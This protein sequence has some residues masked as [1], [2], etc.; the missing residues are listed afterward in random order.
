MDNFS[1]ICPT[2]RFSASLIFSRDAA[3]VY[4]SPICYLLVM[5]ITNLIFYIFI[6][7]RDLYYFFRTGPPK[8]QGRPPAQPCTRSFAP[9]PVTSAG[10]FNLSLHVCTCTTGSYIMARSKYRGRNYTLSCLIRSAIR[11][12][13]WDEGY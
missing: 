4:R 5:P 10:T 1:N 2:T 3:A 7:N 8:S 13:F 11:L 12:F 6:V 9:A